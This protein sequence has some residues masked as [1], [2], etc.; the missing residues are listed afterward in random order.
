MIGG[1]SSGELIDGW[2]DHYCGTLAPYV[3]SKAASNVSCPAGSLSPGDRF[4]TSLTDCICPADTYL[5]VNGAQARCEACVAGRKSPVGSKAAS[6]CVYCEDAQ[7]SV[8]R[9]GGVSRCYRYFSNIE[10]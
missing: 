7:S 10:K 2:T 1:D 6:D 8:F 5:V 3:C 9:S 4:I